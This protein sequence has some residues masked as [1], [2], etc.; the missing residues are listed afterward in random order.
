MNFILKNRSSLIYI[1]FQLES[2][3]KMR[4]YE[5]NTSGDNHSFSLLQQLPTES[6]AA[7]T[8]MLDAV[9]IATAKMTAPEINHLHNVK[10]SPRS[11]EYK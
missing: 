10:H 2:F 5:T 7:L 8:A 3:L 4:L 1:F 11:V 9:Q 6:T